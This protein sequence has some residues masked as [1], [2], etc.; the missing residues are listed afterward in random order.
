MSRRPQTTQDLADFLGE[1]IYRTFT[2]NVDWK[3]MNTKKQR[4]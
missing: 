4:K 1:L 2:V 3:E